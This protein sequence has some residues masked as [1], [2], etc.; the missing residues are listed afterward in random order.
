MYEMTHWSGVGP[1][2]EINNVIARAPRSNCSN[3]YA[4]LLPKYGTLI[5]S[6]QTPPGGLD[7]KAQ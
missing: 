2:R 4:I 3:L 7:G 5:I 6:S 1:C